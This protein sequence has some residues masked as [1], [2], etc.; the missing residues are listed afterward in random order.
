MELISLFLCECYANDFSTVA[1]TRMV[2]QSE[3]S[4]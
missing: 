1:M 2:I 3:K 4:F